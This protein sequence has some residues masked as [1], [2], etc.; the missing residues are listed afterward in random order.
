MNPL[1]S[2]SVNNADNWTETTCRPYEASAFGLRRDGG[3]GR[4]RRP[5]FASWLHERPDGSLSFG[6]TVFYSL[7]SCLFGVSAWF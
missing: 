1:T 7:L 2:F 3:R 6:A 5:A 4:L